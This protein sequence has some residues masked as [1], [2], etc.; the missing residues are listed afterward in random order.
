[1]QTVLEICINQSSDCKTVTITDNTGAYSLL[2]LTGWGT[3]NHNLSTVLTSTLTI[4]KRDNNGVYFDSPS[5]PITLLPVLPN[6]L[7]TS[8]DITAEQ[9]G[10]G[11]D[12]SFSD[13][14]YKFTYTVTGDDS[15]AYTLTTETIAGLVC[16]LMCCFKKKSDKVSTCICD[17][18]ELE[19][20]FVKLW[21]YMR[22]YE[23]ARDCANLNQMQKYI[24]KITKLCES[25]GC[26]CD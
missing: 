26:G 25:C 2:N 21:T 4:S 12:A 20:S 15:G 10:Y 22:L 23:G 9:A 17:C 24:D 18:E 8:I 6:D 13:G 7:Y 11:V 3:P 16:N 5:S 1:M 14:I 19:Q